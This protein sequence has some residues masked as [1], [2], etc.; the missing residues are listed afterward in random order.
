MVLPVLL[1]SRSAEVA[2]VERLTADGLDVVA[3]HD[4]E[5]ATDVFRAGVSSAILIAAGDENNSELELLRSFQRLNPAVPVLVLACSK[6]T[7]ALEYGAYYVTRVSW[8]P[9]EVSLLVKRAL[10]RAQP[11]PQ[12]AASPPVPKI[13]IGDSPEIH[14]VRS[15]LDRLATWPTGAL[16]LIGESGT[17][18]RT[19]ARLLHDMTFPAG[20]FLELSA[21][22]AAAQLDLL[23]S[24]RHADSE[25]AHGGIT[26]FT[27]EIADLPLPVQSRLLH[28]LQPSAPG[29]MRLVASSSRDLARAA[30]DGLVRP[31]LAYRFPVTI[32]LPPLR[33]RAS[34]VPLL[35]EHFLAAFC[36]A[37]GREPC[38]LTDAAAERLIAHSW[39]GNVRELA[40]VMA[41]AVLVD[42]VAELGVHSLPELV[43]RP[44]SFEFTL[45]AQ[46]IR[47]DDLEREVLT[48]ALKVASG[49]QTR[50]AALLGLTRDQMR[51][52]MAKF[53][54]VRESSRPRTSEVHLLS[55]G[56]DAV[57]E[58]GL[59]QSGTE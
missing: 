12:L 11:R 48:Q 13:L 27:G 56:P 55:R 31:E 2:L 22:R 39:P 18:K 35:A 28:L 46:G 16:L 58:D 6:A 8:A 50:A 1:V 36:E 33:R 59:R 38:R 57:D 44:K 24:A 45:P 29:L 52:R 19:A 25:R 21:T 9:H 47:F 7:Q 34:D 20:E 53:N 32:E 37:R 41:R 30:R 43:E 40:N 15:T 14:D 26:L 4:P 10:G 3:C 49:N 5:Q 54:M 23:A 51:Y 42:Q 17:G